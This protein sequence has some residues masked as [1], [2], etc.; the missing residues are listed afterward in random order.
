[1]SNG[2]G[3][4]P[5]DPAIANA[6][7]QAAGTIPFQPGELLRF[8][9]VIGPTG[10]VKISFPPK[11]AEAQFW[12]LMAYLPGLAMQHYNAGAGLQPPKSPLSI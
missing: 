10:V 11:P 6:L 12:K 9:F 4:K 5:V 8:E 3:T 7:K 2:D 1:M